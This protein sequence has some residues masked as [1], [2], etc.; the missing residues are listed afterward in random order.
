MVDKAIIIR[1]EQGVA[2]RVIGAIQDVTRARIE[3][4]RL[5]LLESV[6]TNTTV[7][8]LIAG[9][10]VIPDVGPKVLY[11]NEAF[12]SMTGYLPADVI[13]GSRGSYTENVPIPNPCAFCFR[14]YQKDDPWRW[15]WCAVRNPDRNSGGK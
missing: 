5:K 9:I 12:T 10:E 13:N 7:A 11:V 14:R 6:V 3:E 1:D 8:V 4:Q 15:N 2:I